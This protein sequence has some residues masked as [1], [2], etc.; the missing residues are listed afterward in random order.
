MLLPLNPSFSSVTTLSS[1]SPQSRRPIPDARNHYNDIVLV[2][3][4]FFRFPSNN[5]NYS[6][7]LLLLWVRT[8]SSAALKSSIELQLS[9]SLKFL[10]QEILLLLTFLLPFTLSCV[11]I[12]PSISYLWPPIPRISSFRPCIHNKTFYK[13]KKLRRNLANLTISK[14]LL[15]VPKNGVISTPISLLPIATK[16]MNDILALI[17]L[18]TT[19]SSYVCVNVGL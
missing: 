17:C 3:Q 13:V 4:I 2:A 14:S 16:I 9:Q 19:Y 18:D 10:N 7:R 6:L 15:T 8:L 12:N 5:L 1:K 11:I